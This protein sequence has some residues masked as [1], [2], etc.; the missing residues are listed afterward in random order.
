MYTASFEES[1]S[2]GSV[3]AFAIKDVSGSAAGQTVDV[4]AFDVRG[5]LLGD[6]K[7]TLAAGQ[8]KAYTTDALFGAS[9]FQSLAGVPLARL[10]FTG[11]DRIDVLMLQ[12]RGQSLAAMPTTTVLT[13]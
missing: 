11:T 5:N 12:V 7:V 13:Q 4:Q 8:V 3:G 1:T 10:E 6:Q 9:T 2:N